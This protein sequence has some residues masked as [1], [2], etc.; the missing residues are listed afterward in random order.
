[1]VRAINATLSFLWSIWGFTFFLLTLLLV[2]PFYLIF[3]H[4]DGAHR[5]KRAHQLSR[6]WAKVLFNAF[7]IKVIVHGAEKLKWHEPY[8]VVANH[9]SQLDIPAAALATRHFIKF[10]AKAELQQ[11]P[12]LGKIIS[13][14]YLTVDR[15]SFRARAKSMEQMR[16]A[17]DAGTS[18][19][20]FPEGS[21]NRSTKPLQKFHNGAF[22]L[23]Q[24]SGYRVAVLTIKGSGRCLPAG[25]WFQLK[26][27]VIDCYWETILKPTSSAENL[28]AEATAN[29]RERLTEK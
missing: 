25:S 13:E 21:R 9:V 17:L 16:E 20:I 15:K 7:G 28:K 19:V 27:G 26:P 11:M 6:L 1:M 12:L 8:I 3:L 29:I 24:Q 14:L 23:S 18:V 2:T 22:L 5:Q 10:L 4:G